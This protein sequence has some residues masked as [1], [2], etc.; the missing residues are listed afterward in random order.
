MYWVTADLNFCLQA[1]FSAISTQTLRMAEFELGDWCRSQ[2][3]QLF[4][5]CIIQLCG[6]HAPAARASNQTNKKNSADSLDAA[7]HSCWRFCGITRWFINGFQLLRRI[8]ISTTQLCHW[9]RVLMNWHQSEQS[10]ALNKKYLPYLH[11]VRMKTDG[12]STFCYN[13]V[14]SFVPGEKF[15]QP[16]RNNC[17]VFISSKYN[18]M[19]GNTAF[20]ASLK[21]RD[22]ASALQQKRSDTRKILVIWCALLQTTRVHS[23]TNCVTRAPSKLNTFAAPPQRFSFIQK[24]C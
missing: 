12:K 14:F 15:S 11:K 21:T 4:S 9:L 10:A 13:F 16:S 18:L 19:V 6:I 7:T 2:R 22:W 17:I 5:L 20:H 1:L 3:Q 23:N 8:L 24:L